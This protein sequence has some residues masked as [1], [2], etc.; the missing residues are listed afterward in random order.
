M[1]YILYYYKLCYLT[2]PMSMTISMAMT[3]DLRVQSL[4]VA[5]GS[6]IHNHEL[7]RHNNYTVLGVNWARPDYAIDIIPT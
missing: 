1:Q 6:S 2:V 5:A 3:M 4:A 7:R